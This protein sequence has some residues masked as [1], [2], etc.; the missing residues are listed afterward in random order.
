[1]AVTVS[2][3]TSVTHPIVCTGTNNYDVF[4]TTLAQSADGL[5]SFASESNTITTSGFS[6][7]DTTLILLTARDIDDPS[8]LISQLIRFTRGDEPTGA[9]TFD[10]LTYGGQDDDGDESLEFGEVSDGSGGILIDLASCFSSGSSLKYR[11][12]PDSPQD[13][14]INET[15]QKLAWSPDGDDGTTQTIVVEAYYPGYP[16]QFWA[17][18]V[19][20]VADIPATNDPPDV[21]LL[22]LDESDPDMP[23][24]TG[25]IEDDLE[26]FDLIR[27]Q[28]V[29]V[30]GT[31]PFTLDAEV[32]ADGSFSV[33]LDFAPFTD[34]APP[35]VTVTA[36]AIEAVW[37]ADA[38]VFVEL[39]P[40]GS[41]TQT[42]PINLSSPT[43]SPISYPTVSLEVAY[44]F[45]DAA[46]ETNQAVLRGHI[47]YVGPLDG[48]MVEIQSRDYVGSTWGNWT[49]GTSV[50][51][52]GTGA[53]TFADPIAVSGSVERR[54][55][56]AVVGLLDETQT[57]HWSDDEW[58]VEYQFPVA[59]FNDD[60]NDIGEWFPGATLSG[61]IDPVYS[62]LFVE[63][64]FTGDGFP[65][66]HAVTDAT[67]AFS[68]V[69]G[70]LPPDSED[71]EE[72]S[73][74]VH[75]RVVNPNAT[76]VSTWQPASD[77]STPIEVWTESN[78]DSSRFAPA[79]VSFE[80]AHDIGSTN[81]DLFTVYPV[82][83]G[84]VSN[85][86]HL[87][88][89]VVQFDL[90]GDATPDGF[91][92]P[93]DSGEFTYS[94]PSLDTGTVT[95]R[96][97]LI[98]LVSYEE[99]GDWAPAPGQTLPGVKAYPAEDLTFAYV[100]EPPAAPRILSSFAPLFDSDEDGTTKVPWLEGQ[101][102]Y[103]G[104]VNEVF[105]N[106]L[107][108][109]G[110][111]TLNA[112]AFPDDAGGFV[113]A[114][115]QRFLATSVENIDV[116]L[117]P[118]AV[119]PGLG[120]LVGDAVA[121]TL[122]FDADDSGD[123][124]I[125][126]GT[127]DDSPTFSND[128][129]HAEGPVIR[130]VLAP[131]TAFADIDGVQVLVRAEI[132]VVGTGDQF[133]E[134]S[135]ISL[136]DLIVGADGTYECVLYDKPAADNIAVRLTPVLR[137]AGETVTLEN[138]AAFVGNLTIPEASIPDQEFEKTLAYTYDS[139][140]KTAA[141]IQCSLPEFSDVDVIRYEIDFGAPT[142]GDPDNGYDG[143]A[144][145]TPDVTARPEGDGRMHY[146][147][148]P[149][150]VPSLNAQVRA[151]YRTADADWNY[152]EWMSITD[153]STI[154]TAHFPHISP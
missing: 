138:E 119:R 144:D 7:S 42:L 51:A 53:F 86:V 20:E 35:T 24:L 134:G 111:D 5:V 54:Y 43:A 30:E 27:V 34:D 26:T 79:F 70:E 11:L 18:G 65:D 68:F 48:M 125:S 31:S 94:P 105:I 3:G 122:S 108:E 2:D 118:I 28:L 67:G 100:S 104:N 145:G 152:T 78:Y 84:E 140:Q 116:T 10:Q 76:E 128:G 21:V 148:D 77:G 92:I 112:R 97:R 98:D 136:G 154:I 1:M 106:V 85:L 47:D 124:V 74:A 62:D 143:T 96:A 102:A 126:F 8:R 44:P 60:S 4:V 19:F 40:A 69:L 12:S 91:V 57:P 103:E 41:T 120:R 72:T 46:Q 75:A 131:S 59:T 107:L 149:A 90:D 33:P 127:G 83:Q 13:A 9:P 55:R 101:I 137:F 142:G 141:L 32:G 117:T 17:Q 135:V 151:L 115:P 15:T 38:S 39:S 73:I 16:D 22:E 132:G 99:T 110:D 66:C 133:V 81:S 113:Y 64:D 23:L 82:I 14:E 153:A 45:P 114:I 88:M 29:F 50:Q 71:P 150:R 139:G 129:S 93:D 36:T 25:R 87:T 37:D 6:E 56:A 130:G 146:W 80:I 123:T 109:N 58:T 61:S 89:P 147:L 63:I 49:A 95:V 52:D 121:G